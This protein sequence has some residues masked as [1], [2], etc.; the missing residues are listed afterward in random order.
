MNFFLGIDIGTTN[1]KAIIFD[2]QW[3]EVFSTSK[4]I[5]T[6][7]P[8]PG[9][10]EQDPEAIRVDTDI[11]LEECL[12]FA[13]AGKIEIDGI[14]LSAAMHSFLAVDDNFK[15]VSKL[16]TWSDLRAQQFSNAIKS[17]KSLREFREATNVPIHPMLP[18]AKWLWFLKN[19]EKKAGKILSLKDFLV[20]HWF[21]EC[22]SDVSTASATGFFDIRVGDWNHNLLSALNLPAA[23]LPEVRPATEVL[24]KW[25]PAYQ[26]KFKKYQ[27]PPVVL[28]SSDGCLANLAA[29]IADPTKGS[30]SI[31]TSGAVR[32]TTAAPIQRN[33]T[34][35]CYPV[36]KNYYVVGGATNNGG[37]ILR[38]FQENFNRD[39]DTFWKNFD[40]VLTNV[41][42]G[43]L[44]FIPY[45]FGE[46]AP[47]WEPEAKG[48]YLGITNLHGKSHF[49][50]AA[51]E[52]VAFSLKHILKSLSG[53]ANDIETLIADGGFTR[54]EAWVQLVC[55]VLHV[56]IEVPAT[57]FGAAKGAAMIARMALTRE[58]LQQLAGPEEVKRTYYP[59]EKSAK[60]YDALFARYLKASEFMVQW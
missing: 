30:L 34:L 4:E 60:R 2:K 40:E 7:T 14:G 17:D 59:D 18:L 13:R 55:N 16:I 21:G 31:G 26:N 50:K 8:A 10:S 9:F 48:A 52:G 22:I 15:P 56:K 54:S 41:D 29:G 3:D 49:L 1:I 33:N 5:V 47:L 25:T 11:L 38:W 36:L 37:N 45:I 39:K 12:D 35:F 28:G 57:L 20:Y 51:V 6:A 46:R 32:T 27:L 42:A 44:L 24:R 19:E 53:Q 23:Q 43:Q 58:P